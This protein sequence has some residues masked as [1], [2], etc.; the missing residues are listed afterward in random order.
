V[1]VVAMLS[2]WYGEQVGGI[3][4]GR[5]DAPVVGARTSST[6][7]RSGLR[8]LCRGRAT[9]AARCGSG[10]GADARVRGEGA[11]VDAKGEP[12]EL[13]YFHSF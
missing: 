4:G 12:M 2:W 13:S 6:M 10:E 5:G 7:G 11:E 8:L 9:G 3:L 1:E